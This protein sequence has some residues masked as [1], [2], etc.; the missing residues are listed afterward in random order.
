MPCHNSKYALSRHAWNAP[1]IS[2]RAS[3]NALGTPLLTPLI[4]A[5]ISLADPMATA[6]IWWS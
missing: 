6:K 4:G 5:R 2:A 1:L 3:A